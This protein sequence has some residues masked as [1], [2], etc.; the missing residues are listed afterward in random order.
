MGNELV[1]VAGA[2]E[3]RVI[4]MQMEVSKFGHESR[5]DFAVAGFILGAWL[6]A[7]WLLKTGH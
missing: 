1:Y 4:R 7:G 6:V 3:E 2:V 5:F